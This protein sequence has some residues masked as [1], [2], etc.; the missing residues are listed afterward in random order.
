MIK[1][2][3]S[4]ILSAA[5]RIRKFQKPTSCIFQSEL[6]KILG[7]E[8]YVK[9]EYLNPVHSFKIR[10]AVN[11]VQQLK[12]S[13]NIN[14]IFTASTGNHGAAMSF[15]CRE[16]SI[17][18]TVG[19]PVNADRKKIELIEYFGGQL[20]FIGED[21]DET[22]LHMLNSPFQSD[23]I[24]IEDGARPEIVAGT[25]TIG[26]EILNQLKSLDAIIVPVGNGALVGGIGTLVKK[27][28]PN[29]KIIGIQAELASCMEKSF[30]ARKPINT[31]TCNTFAGGMAVRVAIPESVELLLEVVDEMLL[32]N[33]DEMKKAMVLYYNFTSQIIEGAGAAALAASLRYS[34]KFKDKKI[35]IIATGA[36]VDSKLKENVFG[37]NYLNRSFQ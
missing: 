31:K 10:G 5:D 35:C 26:F 34:N 21:L 15:A 9:I 32:V 36:N 28:N 19:V 11:L 24:F 37:H 2:S 18:I 4:Q 12:E 33:E 7:S 16:F 29:I 8:S 13:K 3:I 27:K 17:P 25:A 14:H 23:Q 6:S 22:K 30:N 1:P 20:E